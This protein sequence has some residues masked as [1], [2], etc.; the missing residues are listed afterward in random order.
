MRPFMLAVAA[1]LACQ[2][3]PV[4]LPNHS[5]SS[6]D[7]SRDGELVYAVDTDNG[8]VV[9]IDAAGEAKVAEVLVGLGA[10][11]VVVGPD[12]TLYVANRRDPSVSV[13][14]RGEWGSSARWAAGA[15][16]VGLAVS[17]DGRTLYVVSALVADTPSHGELLA[18]DAQT[19]AVQ[20]QLALGPEPRGVALL[21]SDW[22]V[23]AQLKGG[24]VT[25]VDLAHRQVWLAS[26]SLYAELNRGSKTS[27]FHPRDLG[28]V[29]FDPANRRVYALAALSR[30]GAHDKR[31]PC[32]GK[33]VAPPAVMALDT[34]GRPLVDPVIDCGPLIEPHQTPPTAAFGP[35]EAGVPWRAQ[36]GS[37]VTFAASGAYV[38]VAH[39]EGNA[40]AWA[41]TRPEP[42]VSDGW[43]LEVVGRRPT[44]VVLQRDDRAVW[45]HNAL[46]HTLTKFSAAGGSKVVAKT[47]SLGAS[48]VFPPDVVAGRKLFFDATD[49]RLTSGEVG[50]ACATCHLEGGHE[51]GHVWRFAEGP[52]QTS[53]LAGA[54]LDGTAPFH[55][56][57][58]FA[59][60]EA[61]MEH[62]VAR[63]G[64]T[65][66]TAPMAGQ[67]LAYLRTVPALTRAG[68]PSAEGPV[69]FARAGCSMC[70][71]GAPLT[72]D[73]LAHVGTDETGFSAEGVNVPSLLG[74]GRTAPYLH[75]GS[76]ATLRDAIS[77]H[78]PVHGLSD[79]ELEQLVKYVE[80]L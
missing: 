3:R 11:L 70:H 59:T 16:P 20:W 10:H 49:V 21:D 1:C 8:T 27:T 65:G 2:S 62:T 13:I 76:A 60:F 43:N 47:I 34:T 31:E 9:V 41:F 17:P 19:G 30:E 38:W 55:W 52:R 78:A 58:A 72:N 35:G 66:L 22:A 57:G 40:V 63:M 39:P 48:E 32:V 23:V 68:A 42:G 51:D 33:L 74:V 36:G 56:S 24:E 53:S 15:E 75:D 50:V 5:A 4:G 29:G 79:A 28:V 12:D 64:G 77:A 71:A 46:D 6:L 7:L 14:R 44:G 61:L 54:R 18:L 25:W 26:T 80:T 45:V 37:A 67:L 73:K 69:L